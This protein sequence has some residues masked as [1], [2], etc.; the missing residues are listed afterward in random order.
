MKKVANNIDGPQDTIHAL[1]VMSCALSSFS[2]KDKPPS[3]FD[4]ESGWQNGK[5]DHDKIFNVCDQENS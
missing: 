2:C 5:K 1:N 4:V 3:D